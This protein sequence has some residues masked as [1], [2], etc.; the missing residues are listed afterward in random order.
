MVKLH[1]M[2]ESIHALGGGGGGEEMKGGRGK[3][4]EEAGVT[5]SLRE[6]CR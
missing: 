6:K 1:F 3:E 2:N 5:N 4:K